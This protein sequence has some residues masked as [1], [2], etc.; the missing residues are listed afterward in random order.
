R[1]P[2]F[3]DVSAGGNFSP[4]AATDRLTAAI[5]LVR[6]AGLRAEAESSALPG[7]TLPNILDLHTVAA[8]LRGYVQVAVARGLLRT[9]G[10]NFRPQ[11]TLTRAEL[12]HAMSVLARMATE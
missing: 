5:A 6:A 10:T 2:I 7:G 9:E 1:G 12:A 4:A 11:A 3:T 8:P